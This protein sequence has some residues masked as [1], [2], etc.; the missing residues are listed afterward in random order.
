MNVYLSVAMNF[1]DNFSLII[2]K[3]FGVESK[4]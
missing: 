4:I 2:Y 3:R 1:A